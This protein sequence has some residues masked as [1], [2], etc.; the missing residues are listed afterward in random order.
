M[1]FSGIFEKILLAARAAAADFFE[2][3]AHHR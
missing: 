1:K 3:V 2:P